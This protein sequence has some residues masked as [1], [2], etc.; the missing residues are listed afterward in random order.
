MAVYLKSYSKPLVSDPNVYDVTLYAD[1]KTDMD[2]ITTEDI[3]HMPDDA[4]IAPGSVVYTKAL[5][6]AVYDS[7]G[8]WNWADS[9]AT[10]GE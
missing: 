5:E 10:E 4:E 3:E 1:A 8:V 2:G 6:I 7:E 9:N